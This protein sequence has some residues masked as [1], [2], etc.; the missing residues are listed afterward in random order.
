MICP[1]CS[2]DDY[3]RNGYAGT[4]R[5]NYCGY[6]AKLPHIRPVLFVGPQ[7]VV[8]ATWLAEQAEYIAEHGY[9]CC[10][11]RTIGQHM[12]DCRQQPREYRTIRRRG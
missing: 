8:D 7:R 11:S 9:G 3:H 4:T 6:D 5:C 1:N 2:S 12:Y 10:G